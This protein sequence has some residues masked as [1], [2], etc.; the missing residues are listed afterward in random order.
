[1][2]V[3]EIFCVPL[4][5]FFYIFRGFCL[6]FFYGKFLE[7]RGNKRVCG[8]AAA[9]V[10]A[11]YSAVLF[12]LPVS[13]AEDYRPS[14]W[15]SALTLS[16]LLV[17]AVCFYK[18]FRSIT[19]FLAV[20]FQAIADISR[21]TI[22]I[23]FAKLGDLLLDL[24]NFLMDQGIVSSDK[25]FGALINVFITGV[26]I[27][28][29]AAM[30]V[31]MFLSL[32][33]LA[34]IFCEKDHS[35]NGTELLFI[36]TPS[37]AGLMIC[38]LL[39]IIMISAEDGIPK[40][41]YEK[42]PLLILIIPL[43]L[44][45][46]LFSVFCGVKLFQDMI[47]RGRERSARL[48]L[49]NQ[50]NAMREHIEETERVYSELKR[51]KHNMKNTLSVITRLSDSD[52]DNAQKELKKYLS[53]MGGDLD[54]AEF[55]F[56]T[57]NTISDALLN[58]KYNEA[59]RCIRDLEIEADKLFFPN[60]LKIRGYDIGVILGNALDNAIEACVRLRN[61]E[62]DAD[63]Y[64]RLFSSQKGELLLFRIENSFDGILNFGNREDLPL[65]NKADKTAHGI[66]L[67][68]IRSTAEKYGGTMD[69]MTR[70]REFILSVMMKNKNTERNDENELRSNG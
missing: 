27:L 67:Y 58:M 50:I 61:N 42:Y 59:K 5:L 28:E 45:L 30:S 68:N 66:G 24:L 34:V 62:P 12:G 4:N 51:V 6:T 10:F 36:L 15:K 52:S 25:A 19:L 38:T 40:L 33:K 18:G 9:V 43:I 47:C 20:T 14:L 41:L 35:I 26:L 57:G 49:E 13:A 22:A 63:V 7:Y 17:I 54:K 1:M 55:R 31:F 39:R 21:Y 16:V 32:K 46:S 2:S 11:S 23:L 29:Y 44:L 53:E 37:A 65:T 8:L 48:V 3:Y 60:S 69:F 70:D 64:I 56:K